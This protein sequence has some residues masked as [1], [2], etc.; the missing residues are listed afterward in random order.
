MVAL[1]WYYKLRIETKHFDS[2]H[3]QINLPFMKRI[4]F[5]LF[6]TIV[7]ELVF[8][9][10]SKDATLSIKYEILIGG[11]TKKVIFTC[12]IPADIENAQKVNNTTFNIEPQLLFSKNGNKYA[13][14]EL[15]TKNIKKQDIIIVS[16]VSIS[17]YDL[18]SKIKNPQTSDTL[19]N[20]LIAEKNI[21]IADSGIQATAKALRRKTD[22][23]TAKKIYSFV[24]QN[25]KYGGYNMADRGAASALKTMKGDCSEFADLF[26]ALCRANYI[27]A[28]TVHGLVTGDNDIPFHA[29]TEV[30]LQEYGWVRFD[31]TTGNSN[32][33]KSLQNRYVQLSN[34]KN[35]PVLRRGNLYAY[36]FWGQNISVVR[37]F[38][39][40]SN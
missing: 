15:D 17:K 24:N 36:T 14:F 40:S 2:N 16:S 27:P 4:V 7:C 37:T 23:Q 28:R 19:N 38:D 32:S 6:M 26:V 29:W 20:F 9:Q 5:L 30:Y 22:L 13:Q 34:M 3:L 31:P 10:Q 18:S 35:D 8:S 25:I 39:I 12:V 33:F 11:D 21:E 1:W